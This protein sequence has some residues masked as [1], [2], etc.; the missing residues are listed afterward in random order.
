VRIEPLSPAELDR[1]RALLA[2]ALPHDRV[3]VV[4]AEKLFG[5][6]GARTGMT[7]GAFEDE[8]LVGVLAAAGRWIKLIAVEESARRQ[9]I[10]TQLL[11]RLDQSLKLRVC[12]HPGNYLSP[13]LDER[14][15]EGLAFFGA[16]GFRP[17]GKVENLRAPLDRPL[18][19][20]EVPGYQLRR[21]Q[22]DDRAAVLAWI[23]RAFAPVWAHEAG[24]AADGPRHALHAAFADVAPAVPV[25]F[26][27]ADGNNQ[28]LGWFGPAGTEPAHRGKRLGE[29]LLLRCLE[30]V[31]ELPEGGVIAWIGPKEFYRKTVAAVEDRRFLQLERAPR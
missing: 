21:V 18:K 7:L 10:A 26:A 25:A 20:M 15:R 12:D 6:D 5:S 4:D 22:G 2:R 19:R 27:A 14:Y 23:A 28:G 31:R 24:R 13:G 29:A 11:A 9:G 8:V 1:A 30:D 3:D 16:H 17:A